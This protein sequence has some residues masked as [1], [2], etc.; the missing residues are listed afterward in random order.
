MSS[1][2]FLLAAM[3]LYFAA[4]TEVEATARNYQSYARFR[5]Q[6]A[7]PPVT[8]AVLEPEGRMLDPAFLSMMFSAAGLPGMGASAMSN[9]SVVDQSKKSFFKISL[10]LILITW[11]FS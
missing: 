9:G 3:A 5:R 4:Q 2:Y 7:R 10:Y 8:E 1:Q 11:L 6:A